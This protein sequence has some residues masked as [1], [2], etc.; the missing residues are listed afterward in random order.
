[1]SL[2][3]LLTDDLLMPDMPM[4]CTNSSAR[5]VLTPANPCLLDHRDQRLLHRLPGL[6]KAGKVAARPEL[7]DLQVEGPKTRLERA[8]AIAI[9][10]SLAVSAALKAAGADHAVHISFHDDLQNALRHRAQEVGVP[11][12]RKQVGKR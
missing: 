11:A 3:S 8:V 12:L 6:Q 1:M 10:P 4:A 7:G 2:Q 5:R 9:A